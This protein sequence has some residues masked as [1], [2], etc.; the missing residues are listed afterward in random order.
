MQ[1]PTRRRRIKARKG[2][3][4][5]AARAPIGPTCPRRPAGASGRRPDIPTRARVRPRPDESR[6]GRD[7][8]RRGARC[9]RYPESHFRLYGSI[10]GLMV[11]T[12]IAT[13][14]GGGGVADIRSRPQGSAKP[15]VQAP[16]RACG[17]RFRPASG[18]PCGGGEMSPGGGSLKPLRPS[19]DMGGG[20]T[21][22]AR[23]RPDVRHIAT[24]AP[25]C[26]DESGRRLNEAYPP[27]ADCLFGYRLSESAGCAPHRP[28]RPTADSLFGC[29]PDIC[30]ICATS[31][32]YWQSRMVDRPRL[33]RFRS[34]AA[35]A[36]A[37]AAAAAAVT[38][39]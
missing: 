16:L 3:R 21:T 13:R 24:R 20:G 17:R 23:Y 1:R 30:P 22:S 6:A 9:A 32:R 12:P 27:T 36:A 18:P 35:A 37:T 15:A 28:H 33:S 14:G 29:R 38:E 8:G 39:G 34:A 2:R 4:G 5:P 7:S 31:A 19:G 26:P 11:A 25:C 10:P